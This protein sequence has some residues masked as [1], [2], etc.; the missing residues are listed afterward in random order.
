MLIWL[1]AYLRHKLSC[2]EYNAMSYK[3]RRERAFE[4]VLGMGGVCGR[5]CVREV[6]RCRFY[7]HGVG[8]IGTI[9]NILLFLVNHNVLHHLPIDSHVNLSSIR[10]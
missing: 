2:I 3:G 1:R 4:R 6:C 9:E 5:E 10:Q 7:F 8:V